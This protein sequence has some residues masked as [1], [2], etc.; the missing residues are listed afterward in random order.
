MVAVELPKD[1]P[2]FAPLPPAL[3]NNLSCCLRC[4]SVVPRFYQEHHEVWH[5]NLGIALH[6][7]PPFVPILL[8]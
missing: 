4:G 2:G 7:H 3:A 5:A 6:E 1:R 8:A